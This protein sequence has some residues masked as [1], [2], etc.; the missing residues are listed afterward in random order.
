MI[1]VFFAIDKYTEECGYV[2]LHSMLSNASERVAVTILYEN[3]EKAP[4]LQWAKNLA[5]EGFDLELTHQA[6][7]GKYFRNSKD[8]FNSRANYLRLLAPLY[9]REKQ[10]IYSDA[11]VIFTGDIA[12]LHRMELNGAMIALIESGNCGTRRVAER[13]LLS[14]YGKK[15]QDTYYGSGLAVI[16][17][18]SYLKNQKPEACLDVIHHHGSTLIMH[19]QTVWNCVFPPHE[20]VKVDAH[21]IQEPP[22]KKTDAPLNGKTGI[23]HFCG[24]PKPWD[25]FAEHFHASYPIWKKA[26]QSAGLDGIGFSKYLSKPYYEKAW[27]IRKQYKSLIV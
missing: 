4:G 16:D 7:D 26:A 13:E 2:A 27:R 8:L 20:I 22:V 5:K 24:S 25:L 15:D 21:W 23:I 19:E 14:K 1:R 6:I 12:D 11:D 10:V 18:V 17:C 3:H 9:A